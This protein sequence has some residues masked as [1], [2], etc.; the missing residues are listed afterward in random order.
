MGSHAME[1]AWPGY[2]PCL[3]CPQCLTSRFLEGKHFPTVL[4][5]NL[6]ELFVKCHRCLLEKRA[7]LAE[8]HK[9]H[10]SPFTR[11]SG[12]GKGKIVSYIESPKSRFV[13]TPVKKLKET[14][15]L[16]NYC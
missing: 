12:P 9:H 15:L 2:L 11:L 10:I 1:F 7:V 16:D 3:G 13:T 14:E 4:S 5:V 8:G 6:L